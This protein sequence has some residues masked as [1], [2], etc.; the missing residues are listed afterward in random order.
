M[1]CFFMC[2]YL[3]WSAVKWDFY[4]RAREGE[5]RTYVRKGVMRLFIPC[6]RG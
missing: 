2:I 1:Y 4:E 3:V 5:V 6:V